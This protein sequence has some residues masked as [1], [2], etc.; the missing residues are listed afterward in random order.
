[1]P[2]LETLLRTERSPEFEELRLQRMI[3]GAFRYGL[4]GAEGKPQWDRAADMIRR[5]DRYK[6]DGNAEHLIDIANLCMLE[7]V[8]GTHNGVMSQDDAAHTLAKD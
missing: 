4:L 7:F 6:Q 5:L 8:E 1:M 3:M 2:D